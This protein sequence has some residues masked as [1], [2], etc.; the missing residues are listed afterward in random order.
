[1]QELIHFTVQKIKEL[2]EQ[3]NEV[4]ALYLSKSFDFDAR[5]D[6]FLNE[7]LEYFRT[8]GN[9]SH[10]SEVL[11]V[12]NMISTVKR[13][14]N[15]IKME[16]IIEEDNNSQGNTSNSDNVNDNGK[17]VKRTR[18]RPSKADRYVE[19]R[20]ELIKELEKMMGLTEEVRGVLLY[21]LE[22]NKEL[23]EYLKNKIPEIR[24]L[25]KCGS[26]NYF[27]QKEEK[28]DIIGLLKSIFKSEKYELVSK[29]IFAERKCEKK[30]YSGIYFFKD[31]NINQYFK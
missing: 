29:R 27:I 12:M 11:K 2:L 22:N 15:P 7:V 23:K 9:T 19:E 20:E 13:G 16:K 5:F 30:Q 8:K 25:Y 4:Q 10:E 28:R 6:A 17:R 31:L 24:K 14:F 3:F 26:W 21:D 1:M 18:N